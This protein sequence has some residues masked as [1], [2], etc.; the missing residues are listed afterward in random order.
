VLELLSDH[1]CRCLLTSHGEALRIN[2]AIFLQFLE[3]GLLLILD[4]VSSFLYSIFSLL[5][6]VFG[7]HD[8][9]ML[10]IVRERAVIDVVR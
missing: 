7:G 3:E 2:H 5:D 6:L 8:V 4:L 10:S 1:Q 9:S